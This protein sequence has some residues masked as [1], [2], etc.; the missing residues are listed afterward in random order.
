MK[1]Q[2]FLYGVVI[3]LTREDTLADIERNFMQIKESGMNTVVVWPAFFWWEKKESGYPFNT[4]KAILT[5]AERVGIKIIMELAGQLPMM[6]YI[7][8]FQMKDEYYCIDAQG[9]KQLDYNSFGVLNYFHPEVNEQICRIFEQ[10]AKAYRESSALIGYDV[11]NETAFN[12]YDQY[13]MEKFRQWLKKK[14]QTIERLND[15]WERSYTD[16]SQVTFAPWMWMSIMPVADF[17]AFRKASVGMF[18]KNWCDAIHRVDNAH[19]LIADNIGSM[20]T[21][22]T[23]SYERP[24]DDFALKDTVDEIGMSFYP[25]TVK[26]C[27]PPHNRWNT[28]DAFYASSKREGFYIAEMQTHIQAL[29][30][31]TTAVRPYELKLWCC[32]ALAAGAK[33]LIYWMWR[34]FTKGLQT[35]GRGLVDYKNRSTPRLEF[36]KD[37]SKLIQETG[38]LTPLPGKVAILF[39]ELCEDF[40]VFY[41]KCYQSVVDPNIYLNSVC[42]AYHAFF[43]IGVRADIVKLHEIQDYKMLILSNHLVIGKE[44]AKA[45]GDYVR[46]GGIIVCDGKIGVVDEVSMLN[47]D[48]PGGAFN[49]YMGEDYLDSDY[50]DMDFVMNGT[51]YQGY[52]SKELVQITNGNVLATF[53]DGAPAV[54]EKEVGKGKVITINTYLWYGYMQARNNAHLFAE[55]LAKEYDLQELTV[56]A[57][58]KARVSENENDR[59][60]FIFN[61]TYEPVCGHLK[62]QGFD[63]DVTVGA[64]DVIVIKEKKS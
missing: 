54:I 49:A 41:T 56:T 10:A 24:Q 16:F 40:Q 45:L 30:N 18:L 38:P 22:G 11:F 62:G 37:F 35:A 29:F 61:Y 23:G 48:L 25:K 55:Y 39:D 7:P 27:K 19:P 14:Y 53:E 2:E 51:R 60:A 12:S 46:G 4:G 57:P 21:R 26:K 13:T 47:S 15:A 17:G 1:K 58:L 50:V 8:D 6:E 36:A 42:G 3:K 44:T 64:N 5:I 28:F 20:V 63:C 31:P 9:H 32:E 33:G 52:Y 34:P 43:D 59:Y